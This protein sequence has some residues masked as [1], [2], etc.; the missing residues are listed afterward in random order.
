MS[1]KKK[2]T[3]KNLVVSIDSHKKVKEHC[4]NK[5]IKMQGFV[6]RIIEAWFQEHTAN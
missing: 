1:E 6:E 5:D 2:K 4:D 3:V